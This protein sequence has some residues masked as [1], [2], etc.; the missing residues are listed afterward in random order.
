M[1]YSQNNEQEIII[2]LF[3]GNRNG[4][5]IDIGANDGV[6]LSNTFALANFYGWTGLL[7]EASP[8]AYER[9]LKNYELIDR[10]FDFQNVAIGKED[11]ELEFWESGEL[12]RKGDVALV[13]SSVPSELKRWETLNMPFEK[14]SVPMTS[15][16]TMLSRSRHTHFDL[17]SLDI[18]G[19]ELDVL[20][21]IDF[22]ALGIKVAVIEWNSKDEQKYNDIMFPFGFRMVSRNHE[23]LIYEKYLPIFK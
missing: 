18:E 3:K 8:K 14:L 1:N 13:S 9:M 16:A 23:N 21:Q 17:L 10:D 11:G 4:T 22:D 19:M 5:F 15:V 6:T 20:P 7:V 2:N 12:L